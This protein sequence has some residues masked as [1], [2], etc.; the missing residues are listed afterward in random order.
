MIKSG[1]HTPTPWGL[2]SEEGVTKS[3]KHLFSVCRNNDGPGPR[4]FLGVHEDDGHKCVAEARG[5]TPEESFANAALIVK[6]VNA[7]DPLVS[8]LERLID[9]VETGSYESTG[10][11]VE[12]ARA[13]LSLAKDG[14]K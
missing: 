14:T 13:A 1:A 2:W 11:A 6:A 8:A 12:E 10:Q 7:F 3:G 4:G 5:D 9:N